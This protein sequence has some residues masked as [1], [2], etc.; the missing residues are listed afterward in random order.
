METKDLATLIPA[1]MKVM[2]ADEEMNIQPFLWKQFREVAKL[3]QPI[4][5]SMGTDG[6][7]DLMKLVADHGDEVTAIIGIAT[8]KSREWV[9]ALALDYVLR[10]AAAILQVN[11]DFFSQ[12]LAPEL[13]ALAVRLSSGP[14]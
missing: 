9:E 4:R 2:V 5:M 10:L 13:N 12:K 8:G 14:K 3:I 6:E 11:R 1:V 7:L